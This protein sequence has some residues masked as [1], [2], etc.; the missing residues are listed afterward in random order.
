MIPIAKP[1]IEKK[2]IENVIKVL[3]SGMLVQGAQVE[4]FE[5]KIKNLC[6]AKYAVA[7]NSGT[8]ALHTA[9][10]AIGIEPDDEVITTPFTFIATANA[11]RMI[12]AAPVFVDIDENT[13]NIDPKNIEKAVTKRTKAIIAVNLYGQPANYT[14]INNIA[15]RYKLHVI[16]DAAQSINADYKKKKSGNLT[17]ISC[18]SF[19]ATKNIITG[20]G[21]MITTNNKKYYERAKLFRH[22]GQSEE[23][24]YTY[25]DI[26]YNYRMTNISAA[27]GLAQF[28]RL[29][30]ITKRR[31]Q[32]ADKYDKAFKDIVGL[33][34]PFIDE[35]RTSVYHQYTLRV[36]KDFKFTRDELKKYLEEKGIQTAIY[37]PI[38]L[39][40]FKHLTGKN[41]NTK[42]DFPLSE[43]AS[44]EVLSILIHPAL[45]DSEI[46]YIIKTIKKI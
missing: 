21:G 2:D 18:F 28:D 19:Y 25:V 42:K 35:N 1:I 4:E 3:E 24:R 13:Y 17:D 40:H 32:I 20:E 27:L 6:S 16:E 36:T 45:K 26:G 22:H 7:T 30:K 33:Q 23:K 43:K 14:E 15:K 37:Y 11:I 9:L 44:H 41:N 12:G 38:S 5:N 39:H 10:Y 29:D 8:A 34:I 46:E 31:Q